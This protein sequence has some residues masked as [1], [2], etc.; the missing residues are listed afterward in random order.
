MNHQYILM[1]AVAG[2]ALVGCVGCGTDSAFKSNRPLYEKVIQRVQKGEIKSDQEKGVQVPP[3]SVRLPSIAQLPPDLRES[4]VDG[5]IY[6]SRPS[7]NQLLV[8][9]KTWSGK[10]NNM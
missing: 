7:N 9:F 3:G 1:L 6:V 10:G 2:F 4:S 5:E 8:V